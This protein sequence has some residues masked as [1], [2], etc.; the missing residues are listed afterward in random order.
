MSVIAKVPQILDL[1]EIG[2]SA[3][4]IGKLLGVQRKQ[5][6]MVVAQARSFRDPRAVLHIYPNGRYVG[7]IR[8]IQ[9]IKRAWRG[10]RAVPVLAM[11]RGPGRAAII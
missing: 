9:R 10:I 8:K 4:A 5:V 2:Y 3:T 6:T 7:N 11:W 1:W